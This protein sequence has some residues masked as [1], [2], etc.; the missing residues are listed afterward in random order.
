MPVSQSRIEIYSTVLLYSTYLSHCSRFESRSIIYDI[1][2]NKTLL[3]YTCISAWE[4]YVFDPRQVIIKCGVII[5]IDIGTTLIRHYLPFGKCI[6]TVESTTL[7]EITKQP[8]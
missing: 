7:V 2:N 3:H 5:H 4:V 8:Q 6:I 1:T